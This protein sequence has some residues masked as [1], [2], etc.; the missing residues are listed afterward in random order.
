VLSP[1]EAI[2][3]LIIPILFCHIMIFYM[4]FELILNGIAEVT[5]FADRCFYDDWWNSTT[6]DE[7]PPPLPPPHH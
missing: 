6:W 4:M 7:V 2:A 3:T 5:R 1:V